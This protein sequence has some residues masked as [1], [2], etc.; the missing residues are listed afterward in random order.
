[1]SS[2]PPIFSEGKPPRLMVSRDAGDRSLRFP[3]FNPNSPLAKHRETVPVEG[4]GTV[5]SYTVIHTNPKLGKEPFA[6][7]YV[8]FPGPVRIFGR[9]RSKDVTIGARCVAAPDDEFG[10]LFDLVSA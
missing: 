2:S 7:G 6:C 5:Y 10:Y 9:F 1:M 4:Q 3:P 8:N